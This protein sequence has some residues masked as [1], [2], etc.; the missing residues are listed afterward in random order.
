MIYSQAIADK[1]SMSTVCVFTEVSIF[2]ELHPSDEFLWFSCAYQ[3]GS[4]MEY[5]HEN[6][7]QCVLV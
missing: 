3:L 7:E 5:L 6:I 2:F 1:P 4:P